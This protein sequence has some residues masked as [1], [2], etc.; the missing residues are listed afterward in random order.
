MMAAGT[1]IASRNVRIAAITP[2]SAGERRH[3]RL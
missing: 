1:K 3:F 2:T